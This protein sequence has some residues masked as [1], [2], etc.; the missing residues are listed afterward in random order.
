MNLVSIENLLFDDQSKTTKENWDKKKSY[1]YDLF[2]CRDRT[3]IVREDCYSL[4]TCNAKKGQAATYNGLFFEYSLQ[5]ESRKNGCW[6]NGPS[7]GHLPDHSINIIKRDVGKERPKH[8]EN[9]RP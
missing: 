8:I 1:T 7:F 6:D 3:V 5:D 9:C 4:Y 2:F